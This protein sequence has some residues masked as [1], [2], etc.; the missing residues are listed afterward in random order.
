MEQE[1]GGKRQQF[2]LI[3]GHSLAYRAFHALPATLATSRGELTNA[4]YGFTSMLLNALQ[5][6]QPAYLAVAFDVGKTF[7]H[8]R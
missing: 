6:L 5:E 3:D 8:E 2:V 7:R 1:S 4:I